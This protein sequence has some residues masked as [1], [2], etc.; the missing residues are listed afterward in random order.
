MSSY[1]WTLLSAISG[2]AT[3]F[4]YR[5]GYQFDGVDEMITIPNTT[6]YSCQDPFS[7]SLWYKIPAQV[8]FTENLFSVTSGS[9]NGM[10]ILGQSGCMT[11][12]IKS[13][14]GKQL[15]ARC[16]NRFNTINQWYHIVITYDGSLDWTGAKIYVDGVEYG[17]TRNPYYYNNLLSTSEFGGLENIIGSGYH[18]S[19]IKH[20]TGRVDDVQFYDF[21]L[22]STQASDIY[23]SGY[24]TAPTASPVH[25]WKLGEEDTFSTDWTVKDS[26]GSLDGTSVNM[27]EE[28][29]KLGVAYSMDFDGVDEYIDF[30]NIFTF[31]RN[32]AFSF[33]FWVNF[34]TLAQSGAIVSKA[35]SSGT[36]QGLLIFLQ[37]SRVK[38]LLNDGSG[39]PTNNM[40]VISSLLVPDTWYHFVA[41]YDGSSLRSGMNLYNNAVLDRTGELLT[42]ISGDINAS[43]SFN[44]GTR[45][46]TTSFNLA[47]DIM[48]VAKFDSELSA[49][50]VA[51]LYNTTGSNNGVPV[52]P[53]SVGLSPSFYVPLGGQNDTFSTNWTFVDEIN[54]NNGTSVNMEESDKTNETP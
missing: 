32:N 31:D 5:Y 48:E 53:R 39:G 8:S 6:T 3:G 22:N 36:Y 7:V 43:T 49:A 18:P 12:F 42:S 24:V 15:W 23:N 26:I 41:T 1:Y 9:S 27:E 25:H 40:K 35:L 34:D 46:N 17:T 51:L 47:A 33:S 20:F 30:G 10:Y 13:T 16:N 2:G 19:G 50:Q 4:G 45:D 38:F 54:G 21:E 37:N 29:R 44:I 11:L 14:D 28:D 52:D